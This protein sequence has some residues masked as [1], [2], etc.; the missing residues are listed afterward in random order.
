MATTIKSYNNDS[1]IATS[2]PSAVLLSIMSLHLFCHFT[3]PCVV[4]WC[5][6]P[7]HATTVMLL[8]PHCHHHSI[9][10]LLCHYCIAAGIIVMSLWHEGGQHWSVGPNMRKTATYRHCQYCCH[11]TTYV[12][13]V[14][15]FLL[16]CHCM[17]IVSWL[18]CWCWYWCCGLLSPSLL[19]GWCCY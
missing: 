16:C 8:W 19:Y 7:C 17:A 18:W 2:C 4:L 12:A 3:P 14:L 15:C 5:T 11:T 6:A 10:Y 13:T 9:H 1:P